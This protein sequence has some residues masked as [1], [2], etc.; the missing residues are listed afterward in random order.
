MTNLQ[1]RLADLKFG[2]SC[3][4]TKPAR[5]VILVGVLCIYAVA[6]SMPSDN[7]P[8]IISPPPGLR[9]SGPIEVYDPDT[10]YKKINGQAEFYLSAGFVT[11]KS[12]WFEAIEDTD[13][14]VEVNLYHMGD[15]LN[16]F[17]VFSLQQRENAQSTDLARF[18][19][20]TENSI[21][22]VHGPYYVEMLLTGPA[23]AG[24]PLVHLLAEQFIRD[25]PVEV[26]TIEEL[27]FFP[28][29]NRAPGSFAMIPNHA[30]GFDPLDNVFTA[31]YAFDQDRITAYLS[32]RQTAQEA[33]ELAHALHTYFQR[34]GGR[35]IEPDVA[36]EGARM[37]ET[38]GFYDL[39]FVIGH[40]L[41]GVHEASTPEQAE[42]IA[43]M[44]AESLQAKNEK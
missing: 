10:L 39:M 29:Q 38:M 28:S 11:L 8:F 32:K 44:L 41:A 20:Q 30:F 2:R 21:Y 6:L 22:L 16:A 3:A 27:A 36:I 7:H 14:M 23:G 34:Y 17:S 37:I 24:L 35:N 43:A 26:K 13:T 42:K 33:K 25:T 9:P 1:I 12:Q 31:T 5:A 19:Y 4:S 40:Y 18:A 15:L